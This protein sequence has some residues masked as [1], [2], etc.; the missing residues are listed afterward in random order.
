[1]PTL[2]VHGI[3]KHDQEEFR[4]LFRSVR[5]RV[6]AGI[7]ARQAVVPPEEAFF[8]IYWG[9]RGPR[10]WYRGMAL[11]TGSQPEA[12]AHRGGTWL[13][14]RA[15]AKLAA[16]G[17]RTP[18]FDPGLDAL[19]TVL[20]A[21][22]PLHE[23][24]DELGIGTAEL[25]HAVAQTAGQPCRADAVIAR[26]LVRE[27][28]RAPGRRRGFAA[29]PE[30][31][32]ALRALLG[33]ILEPPQA[34]PKG[35]PTALSYPFWATVTAL[36]RHLRSS[37]MEAATRFVGDVMLYLARGAEVRQLVHTAI[38]QASAARPQ[39]PLVLIA[40]SLGGVIAYDYLAD[41]AFH[42]RPAVDLLVTVGSQVALFAE[43]GLLQAS[44]V[45]RQRGGIPQRTMSRAAGLRGA[46][47]NIYDPDDFLSFPIGGIF[48]PEA[49]S[50]RSC[51]AGKPFPA[52][53][54][55]YWHNDEVYAAI[56]EAY[57]RL[58]PAVQDGRTMK[59]GQP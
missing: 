23:L 58:V 10:T 3:G 57:L 40:H 30:S 15:Q 24:L 5:D 35:I 9:D 43:Y 36:A 56:A 19:T 13:P 14:A 7:A 42:D 54:S 27:R 25:V 4:A 41:P 59:G 39:E 32:A 48:P 17:G 34:M 20:S 12:P 37:I 44:Q 22:G 50:D 31:Q 51:P 11:R 46:W 45:A 8:P 1:M 26:L 38:W 53:H 28:L 47:L 33:L 55:A 16:E 6:R 29:Q 52:S 2:F 49:G 18:G 21:P